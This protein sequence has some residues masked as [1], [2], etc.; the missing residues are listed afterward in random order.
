MFEMSWIRKLPS[1]QVAEELG[2][3]IE[4]IYVARSRVLKRLRYEV[5]IL[6]DDIV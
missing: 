4:R 5:A 3:G 1:E 6:S 2:V